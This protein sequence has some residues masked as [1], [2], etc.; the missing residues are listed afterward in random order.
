M[1]PKCE[2]MQ[3][4]TFLYIACYVEIFCSIL[5]IDGNERFRM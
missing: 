5:N 1:N 2:R 3:L 4:Y